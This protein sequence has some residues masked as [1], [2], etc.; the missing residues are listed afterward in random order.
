VG[1]SAPGAAAED[2]VRAL[3]SLGYSLQDA[4]RAVRGTLD[5]ATSPLAAT[6]LIR[7]ALAWIAVR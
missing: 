5:A 1:A 6:E 4:D 3:V 2:A 7:N